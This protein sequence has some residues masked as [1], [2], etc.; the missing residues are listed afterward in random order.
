MGSSGSPPG[1]WSITV[2]REARR[3]RGAETEDDY[4]ARRTK[5]HT[6]DEASRASEAA[7]RALLVQ[8]GLM[9]ASRWRRVIGAALEHPVVAGAIAT[10]IGGVILAVIFGAW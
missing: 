3:Y 8:A 2:S 7:R 1:P 10:V 5:P 6:A 4:L 9:E